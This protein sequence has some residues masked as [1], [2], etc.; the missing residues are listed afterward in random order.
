MSCIVCDK[1]CHGT[2]EQHPNHPFAPQVLIQEMARYNR[3]TAIIRSSLI[4]LDKAIQGLQVSELTETILVDVIVLA[5]TNLDGFPNP[6]GA[7]LVHQL[8]F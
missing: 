7:V 1:N 5:G 4:N 3:L 8:L 2:D 6:G